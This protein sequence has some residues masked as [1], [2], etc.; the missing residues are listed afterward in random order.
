MTGRI[1]AACPHWEAVGE[2]GGAQR[3]QTGVGANYFEVCGR[4]QLNDA[5]QIADGLREV[6]AGR[7]SEFH[8]SY[9]C[10]EPVPG[11][12]LAQIK[13]IN[14]PHGRFALVSHACAETVISDLPVR[15]VVPAHMPIVEID[16]CGRVSRSTEAG[17]AG[18]LAA[19]AISREP[20]GGCSSL[21]VNLMARLAS[22]VAETGTAH[23]SLLARDGT[24][25]HFELFVWRSDPPRGE[26][27]PLLVLLLPETQAVDP[28]WLNILA[29]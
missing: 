18:L 27:S 1:V 5:L 22:T 6:L 10:K 17:A 13:A 3:E 8:W 4:S 12:F 11:P 25:T 14:F 19:G 24:A 9:R 28:L 15:F 23:L 7:A 20:S 29:R 16:R 26:S 2:R 21:D